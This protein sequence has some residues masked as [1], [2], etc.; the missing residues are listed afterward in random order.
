[1][2]RAA[3]RDAA[4]AEEMEF[5]R[6]ARLRDRIRALSLGGAGRSIPETVEEADVF[7]LHAEGGQACVQ[8]FF[9]RAG[10]NWGNRAYFP[11][12]STRP[13]RRRRVLDAFLGQFYEDKP[14]PAPDPGPHAARRT[15]NCWP[16]PSPEGR[17]QG[18][19]RPPAARREARAGRPRPDQRPRGAGP[20]DGRKLGPVRSCWPGSARPSAWRRR[21]SGSRSTTTPTSWGPTRSAA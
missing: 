15:A 1:M 19:D 8:V 16:R 4:A 18:R 17:P 20:Q 21:P 14:I 3:D 12:R 11:R 7:A 2:K 6:A 13:T 9:F 5:E 10:Q